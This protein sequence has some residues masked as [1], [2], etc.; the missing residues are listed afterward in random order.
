MPCARRGGSFSP[1][2]AG[3]ERREAQ[4]GCLREVWGCGASARLRISAKA[5]SEGVARTFG[6]RMLKN[7]GDLRFT[8]YDLQF[9]NSQP[10]PQNTFFPKNGSMLPCLASYA[11]ERR[12]GMKTTALLCQGGQDCLGR[13][14]VR[15]TE[16]GR[17][18]LVLEVDEVQQCFQCSLSSLINVGLGAKTHLASEFGSCTLS[19]QPGGVK[20]SA[21]EWGG[22]PFQYLL[23]LNDFA[24]SLS[25]LAE[26]QK[27]SAKVSL[28]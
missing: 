20:I 13:A 11:Q 3:G 28:W 10:P 18:E 1:C 8:I 24:D 17:C 27:L 16:R 15:L 19:R 21:S 6:S 22:I 5:T 9:T 2:E 23:P 25:R 4:R 14:F 26:A 7:S 12:L